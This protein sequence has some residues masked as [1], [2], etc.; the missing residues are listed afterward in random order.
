MCTTL[1]VHHKGTV[2]WFD[3]FASILI[4]RFMGPTWGPSGADR[5]QVGPMFAAWTLLS[6]QFSN[7][8]IIAVIFFF[9]SIV[10][11]HPQLYLWSGFIAGAMN[12]QFYEIYIAGAVLLLPWKHMFVPII[13]KWQWAHTHVEQALVTVQ[14]WDIK[15]SSATRFK[16]SFGYLNQTLSIVTLFFQ[17][18]ITLLPVIRIEISTFEP[19]FVENLYDFP[20]IFMSHFTKIQCKNNGIYRPFPWRMSQW[21]VA[22]PFPE[23]CASMK[24]GSSLYAMNLN[25]IHEQFC[26][27]LFPFLSPSIAGMLQGGWLSHMPL[28]ARWDIPPVW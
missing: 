28:H 3:L 20:I 2:T 9:Q 17:Y 11:Q 1:Y 14:W 6:G 22:P 5:T 18:F 21:H 8:P 27:A 19:F 25:H 23:H 10:I 26:Y 12:I 7:F 24:Y 13:I 16:A 4:A 15:G